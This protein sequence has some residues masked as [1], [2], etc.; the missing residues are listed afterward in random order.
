M[1]LCVMESSNLLLAPRPLGLVPLPS[2]QQLVNVLTRDSM[3]IAIGLK[4]S[5]RWVLS[6][7]IFSSFSISIG[8]S[9]SIFKHAPVFS[10]FR[11]T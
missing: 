6:R 5:I 1:R 8:G 9:A 11:G 4:S 10:M 7:A 3:P 2:A